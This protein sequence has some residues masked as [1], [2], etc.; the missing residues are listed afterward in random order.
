MKKKR[1]HNTEYLSKLFQYLKFLF[2]GPAAD[3]TGDVILKLNM[4]QNKNVLIINVCFII[5]IMITI[6]T[7]QLTAKLLTMENIQKYKT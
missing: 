5:I 7:R 6:K 4:K 1:Q 3:G 2:T